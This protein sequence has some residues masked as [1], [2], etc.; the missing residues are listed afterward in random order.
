[1]KAEDVT[2]ASAT[3][4]AVVCVSAAP[5]LDLLEHRVVFYP[6]KEDPHGVSAILQEWDSGSIQLLG[7]FVDVSL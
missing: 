5:Y 7:E 6:G 3:S 2:D 1:M 4:G